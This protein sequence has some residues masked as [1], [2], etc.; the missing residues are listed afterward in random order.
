MRRSRISS[1][2]SCSPCCCRASATILDAD[3]CAVLLL[4]EE[5]N[6]LVAR[7]AVGIEEEVERGV[8]IPVGKGFAGRV[9]A[10]HSR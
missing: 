10:E 9:A 2:T 3:T 1:S 6:E 5:R 8:R 4:D 7:A